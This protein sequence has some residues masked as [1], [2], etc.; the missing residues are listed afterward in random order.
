MKKLFEQQEEKKKTKSSKAEEK[1]G[2]KRDSEKKGLA[3]AR[4]KASL[5]MGMTV[6]R[7]CIAKRES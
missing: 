7:A 3:S 5:E 1:R 2:M 6:K 4:K